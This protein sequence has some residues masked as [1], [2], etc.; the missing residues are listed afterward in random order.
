MLHVQGRGHVVA[1]GGHGHHWSENGHPAGPPN[2]TARQKKKIQKTH[3]NR[4]GIK[5]K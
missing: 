3:L 5:L 2:L 4:I 1:R